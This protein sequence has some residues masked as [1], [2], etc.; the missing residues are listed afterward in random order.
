MG[1]K[2]TKDMKLGAFLTELTCRDWGSCMNSP[3]PANTVNQ[4][5][6]QYTQA[7]LQN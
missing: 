4:T 1:L 3:Y 6:F 7:N 2:A 5:L